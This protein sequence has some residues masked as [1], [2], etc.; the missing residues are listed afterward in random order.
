MCQNYEA[1]YYI[2]FGTFILLSQLIKHYGKIPT[3]F[4][5]VTLIKIDSIRPVLQLLAHYFLLK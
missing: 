4:E 2:R 5:Y 1:P 3:Y